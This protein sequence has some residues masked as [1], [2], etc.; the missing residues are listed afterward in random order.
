MRFDLVVTRH[1]A[2]VEYLEEKEMIAEGA[3]VISHVSSADEVRGKKVV[4]VLPHNLSCLC[5][6]FTEI[7]IALP[8]ELRGKDLSLEDIRKYIDGPPMTYIVEKVGDKKGWQKRLTIKGLI[9]M[10]A[11]S[12]EYLERRLGRGLASILPQEVLEKEVKV[13]HTSLAKGS[14]SN[15]KRQ[16][17]W[18][19]TGIELPEE[20]QDMPL[21]PNRNIQYFLNIPGG[22]SVGYSR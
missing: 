20:Y 21:S 22:F 14:R 16:Y 3:K 15:F 11:I 6:T 17:W 18:E 19:V 5:E 10:M 12:P 1:Q 13:K 8:P 7:P 2:L 9:G 4:G